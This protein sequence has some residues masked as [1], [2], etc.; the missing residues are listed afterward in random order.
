[1]VISLEVGGGSTLYLIP[2]SFQL[3][4]S[5]SDFGVE[6][7]QLITGALYTVGTVQY[8]SINTTFPYIAHTA[9]TKLYIANCQTTIT[10][11]IFSLEVMLKLFTPFFG[12]LSPGLIIVFLGGLIRWAFSANE[13]TVSHY[14][15]HITSLS[16]T[17]TSNETPLFV[18]CQPVN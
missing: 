11:D 2:D 3:G 13:A 4:L 12:D 15:L 5:L 8:F 10:I 7:I 17:T 16:N 18:Y 6:V 14:F 9:I 1:M